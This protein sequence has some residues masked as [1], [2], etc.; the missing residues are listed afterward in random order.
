[1]TRAS[2][3]LSV[4]G[5]TETARPNHGT[6]DVPWDTGHLSPAAPAHPV[7]AGTATLAGPRFVPQQ[8]FLKEP[9]MHSF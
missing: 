5:Y 4:P 1:M 8:V 6:R 9:E 3:P 7:A 2:K